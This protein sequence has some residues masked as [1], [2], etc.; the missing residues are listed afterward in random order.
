MVLA[1][2]LVVDDAIIVLENIW[3]HIEEG[4]S[5]M[6]AALKGSRQIGFAI[7]AM[8]LT[9]TSVYAPIALIEGMIGQ[10]F[11]EFAIAL[12]GSVIISGVVALTLSPLMCA[13]FLHKN[14]HHLWP[15][16]DRFL[17]GLA[18]SYYQ[19][20]SLIIYR[21]KTVLLIVLVSLGSSIV[22]Y[23][24][25]PGETAPKEDRSLIGIYTPPYPAKIWIL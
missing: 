4:L 12:A 17:S 20:L 11:I 16:I 24:I 21:K 23:K 22:F 25:M 10:L 14:T 3:R 5:P 19:L 9:L 1:V 6:E 2:G 7:V 8:T 18:Q 13:M 15:F